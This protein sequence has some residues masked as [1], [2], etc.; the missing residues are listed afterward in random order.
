MIIIDSSFY[1][2]Y[3]YLCIVITYDLI[4]TPKFWEWTSLGGTAIPS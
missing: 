3:R 4:I 1:M 2:L